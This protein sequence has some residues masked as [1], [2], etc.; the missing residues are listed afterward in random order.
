MTEGPRAGQ[1]FRD[2][3]VWILIVPSCTTWILQPLGVVAF[4]PFIG[5]IRKRFH[6]ACLNSANGKVSVAELHAI[7]G[8]AIASVIM[9][10]G[11]AEAFGA[12]GLGAAQQHLQVSSK[13]ALEWP[14]L[15]EFPAVALDAKVL[16]KIP[17]RGSSVDPLL[18]LSQ[19]VHGPR[20]QP[21]PAPTA[22]TPAS[23]KIIRGI[24]ASRPVT[25]SMS[26]A[27]LHPGPASAAAQ[28]SPAPPEG[29]GSENSASASYYILIIYLCSK[30]HEF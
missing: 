22:K 2:A 16:R 20:K 19:F 4:A 30:R 29:E 13:H 25:R 6:E 10:R 3:G 27:H 17:S 26:K 24:V 8:E 12:C 11:W 15:P 14:E 5:V 18:R 28:D 23:A 9:T 21:R 1:A 7:V